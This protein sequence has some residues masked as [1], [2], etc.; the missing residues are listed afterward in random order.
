LVKAVFDDSQ[1]S[2][3][4]LNN[5]LK[6]LQN[7]IDQL[8]LKIHIDEKAIKTINDFSKAMDNHKQ[9]IQ[10][11]N[12]TYKEEEQVVKNTDGTIEKI[13]RKYLQSGEIIEKTTKIIDK[14]KQAIQQETNA[15]E[16]QN[17]ALEKAI[18]NQDKLQKIIV[19][20]DGQGKIKNKTEQFK[21]N[22]TDITYKYDGQG[23]LNNEKVVTNLEQ[24]RKATENLINS[25]R[26]LKQ[27]LTQLS[28]EGKIS[29]E[30][31]AKLNKAIDNSKNIQQI[32]R[33]EQHLQ[34][35]NRIRE[36]EHKLELA[37]QQAL[38]NAQRIK[39]TH[40]GF[41]DNRALQQYI[42]SVNNLTPRT[43]N[44]NQQLQKT[45][46]QFKQIAQNA[47]SA[48]GAAQQAGMS[49]A[50]MMSTAMVKFPIWMISA[51]AFYAPIR[52]MEDM[53]SRLVEIDTL[54]VD[55]NR[56]MDIPDFKL[57]ELLNEAV[58]ISDQLSSKLTDVLKIMGDFGRM[59]F[60][61]NQLVDITKT[62]QVLQNI[63]D[64]DATAAVDTLTSA[65]L[66]FNITAEDSIKIA[67]Q[68]NEVDLF[69]SPLYQ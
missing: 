6:Q 13:N 31:L 27:E 10:G 23:N 69:T 37:R 4:E 26:K 20:K 67:D 50:E 48:A 47:K 43:A 24:Q 19:N 2:I 5:Q 12:K 8:E 54:L 60:E 11:L 62:A 57:T 45:E 59:G 25:K 18:L 55:I 58:N 65:M 52:A 9:I 63:S 53:I 15:L 61:E 34:N 68:L 44:L 22:F 49:F 14:R 39:T 46:M 36:N 1:K 56:V 38:L 40:G 64:L 21:D 3:N 33:L 29:A 32:Q 7:K 42:D 41:V 16:Q 28:N 51:T 35:L 30:N 17:K 66:N